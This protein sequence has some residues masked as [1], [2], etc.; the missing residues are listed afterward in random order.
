MRLKLA[1]KAL[2]QRWQVGALPS[3]LLCTRDEHRERT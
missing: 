2:V 3:P 1:K